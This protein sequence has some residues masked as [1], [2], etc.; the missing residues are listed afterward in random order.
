LNTNLKYDNN[1][2]V[3]KMVTAKKK[4]AFGGY[5]ITPD[6]DFAK[7]VG[8]APVTPAEMTKKVWVY[9]KAK[10]LAGK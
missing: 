3:C 1:R 6:S 10:K 9:I 8:K 4:P 2:E 5:R 7:I